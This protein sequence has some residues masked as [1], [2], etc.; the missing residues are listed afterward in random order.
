MSLDL[1]LRVSHGPEG[2]ELH[3]YSRASCNLPRAK[4]ISSLL[5]YIYILLRCQNE[6][7]APGK[8][9]DSHPR[10][11]LPITSFISPSSES[12]RDL[13]SLTLSAWSVCLNFS[14]RVLQY[15]LQLCLGFVLPAWQLDT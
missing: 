15:T 3:E 8:R 5:Q 7:R 9:K 10:H 2:K 4:A 1:D 11:F 6:W 12:K 13:P 14:N